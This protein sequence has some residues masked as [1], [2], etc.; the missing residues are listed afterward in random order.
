MYKRVDRVLY[1]LTALGIIGT[2]LLVAD[3]IMTLQAADAF[4]GG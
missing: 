1:G 4:W 2:V 3:V